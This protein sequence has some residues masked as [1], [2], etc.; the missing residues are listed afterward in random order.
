MT[1]HV[2]GTL[3]DDVEV[4]SSELARLG[5]LET[6]RQQPLIVQAREAERAFQQVDRSRINLDLLHVRTSRSNELRSLHVSSECCPEPR[7][8]TTIA[9]RPL[10]VSAA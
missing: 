6:L 7:F 8:S 2:C 3:P 4:I 10:M 5:R 1:K 9:K